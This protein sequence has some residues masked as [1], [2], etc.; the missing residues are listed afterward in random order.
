MASSDSE[1]QPPPSSLRP[2]GHEAPC[3]SYF[4]AMKVSITKTQ[5]FALTDLRGLP[6]RAHMLVMCSMPREGGAVL[7]GSRD[8]FDELIEHINEDLCEGML[9]GPAA[10]A[11]TALCLKLD[12]RCAE[13]L[14]M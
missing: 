11:L 7:E 5:W 14:G 4:R 12:P 1:I 8:A 13:W 3:R 6:E 10:K 2:Q 9:T